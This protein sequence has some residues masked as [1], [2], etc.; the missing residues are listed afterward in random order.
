MVYNSFTVLR[1]AFQ[2]SER[3]PLR[4]EK[5]LKDLEN[6]STQMKIKMTMKVK[7]KMTKEAVAKWKNSTVLKPRVKM[8]RF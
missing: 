1:I 8:H 7:V 4:S 3:G 5:K 6:Y 2:V